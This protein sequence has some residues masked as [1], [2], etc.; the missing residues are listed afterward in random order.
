M[1]SS[2]I[3]APEE[4]GYLAINEKNRYWEIK[5]TKFSFL[6]HYN[7]WLYRI[8][9]LIMVVPLFLISMY[10]CLKFR[11]NK[12]TK[13]CNLPESIQKFT[14]VYPFCV[15]SPLI[16]G[17]ELDFYNSCN[18]I[19][20]VVE[21][22][23]GDGFFST[24]ITRY[25]NTILTYGA[26]LIYET[27]K[28]ATKYNLFKNYLILD[29][30]EIPLPDNSIGTVVMNNLIH[31]LPNRTLMLKEALRVLKPGGKFIFTDNTMGWGV[32]T[33]EQILLKRLHLYSLAEKVLKFKL[34]LF[35]QRLLV[36]K[37]YYEKKSNELNFKILKKINCVS[38]TSMYLSSLFEF[39]N[40]KQG[41]PTREGMLHWT[42]LFGLRGKISNNIN[43]ILAYCYETDGE[44]CDTQGYAYTFLEIKKNDESDLNLEPSS[45]S[46][47]YVCPNC[48]KALAVFENFYSCS[49]C[50]ID[51]PVVD[52]IPILISYKD[53][54]K[55]LDS[56]IEKMRQKKVREFIT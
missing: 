54:L 25:N 21:I 33:W 12:K 50:S 16:K 11:M 47:Q 42:D 6:N 26:D 44:Y 4:F 32:F 1:E 51:Y 8:F 19:E 49:Q 24:L 55:G 9:C 45:E 38:K 39:L 14:S 18:F 56:Y 30:L 41:Q 43:H 2:N 48:K 27:L 29:A 13:V 20:P 17:M 46:I 40:L 35:A 31:H 7:H 34:T 3:N 23:I 5:L 10:Y 22:G 36:D 28:S 53:K 37:D 52:N 15:Y